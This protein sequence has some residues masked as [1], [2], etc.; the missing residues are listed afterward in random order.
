MAVNDDMRDDKHDDTQRD[1]HLARLLAAAGDEAPPAALDAA[2]L[3]A[4]RREVRA[5]PQVAGSGEVADVVR[6]KRNWYVPLSIAA[7]LVLS[8]S[9]VTLVHLEKGDELAQPT[10]SAPP[11]VSAARA[12]TP[13][14]AEAPAQPQQGEAAPDQAKIAEEKRARQTPEAAMAD[15]ADSLGKKQ[16]APVAKTE[17]MAEAEVAKAATP[18]PARRDSAGATVSSD[19]ANS[20]RDPPPAPAPA[21]PMQER[22]PEPFPAARERDAPALAT[23]EA[24]PARSEAREAAAAAPLPAPASAPAAAAPRP[25]PPPEEMRAGAAPP[26]AQGRMAPAPMA[27]PALK[28]ADAPLATRP[29]WLVEL[30]NQPPE[31]WLAQLAAF[32]RE[33]R[34]ADA[35][36]L[37]VEFR[38]RFPDHPASAR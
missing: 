5:Q 27:K 35:D 23:R 11:A 8:V 3:A 36:E 2:L 10:P 22:R 25:V 20:N 4:A 17:S 13:V 26:A 12:P 14:A 34:S 18:A 16:R 37:L 9:L 15:A 28:R 24:V 31:K 33:G 32:K 1:P 6:S 19:A 30:E 38:R 21:A 29:P 7:V